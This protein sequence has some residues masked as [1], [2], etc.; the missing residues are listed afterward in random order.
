MEQTVGIQFG[1]RQSSV[2]NYLILKQ[3][4]Y[5]EGTGYATKL[6]IVTAISDALYTATLGYIDCGIDNGSF[7]TTMF[8]YPS[9][10]ELQFFVGST[11]GSIGDGVHQNI[12]VKETISFKLSSEESVKY[13]VKEI[14]DVS[15]NGEIFDGNGKTT[16]A[17][18]LSFSDRDIVADK[19][20]YAQAIIT[21][22]T[23]RVAYSVTITPRE[24]SVENVYQS[25]FYAVF[26]GGVTMEEVE[27]PPGAEDDYANGTTC[28][29]RSEVNIDGPSGLPVPYVD[30]KD[31]T[32]HVDYCSQEVIG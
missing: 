20:V 2:N 31:R 16:S 30:Q 8:A 13:P 10:E 5:P 19:V 11:H 7:T 32:I 3:S 29:W 27:P 12:T 17:P 1:N 23:F 6:D 14:V 24:D 25:V 15:W 22:K 26:D 9:S 28:G 21:Y 4:D 18:S